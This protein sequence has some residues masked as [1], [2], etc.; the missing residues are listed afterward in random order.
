MRTTFPR[1]LSIE[2]GSELSHPVAPSSEG[3]CPSTGKSTMSSDGLIE[4]S[5]PVSALG[6]S[7]RCYDTCDDPIA[8][9]LRG[10]AAGQ[11]HQPGPG[12]LYALGPDTRTESLG[13]GAA[14]E[15]NRPSVG[16]PRRTGFE[17][18]L[19]HRARA[20]PRVRLCQRRSPEYALVAD[21]TGQA[22]AIEPLQEELCRSA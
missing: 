18:R 10:P 21:A 6:G 22:V 19:G 16:L 2:S 1:R 20:A 11:R 4:S 9:P 3:R 12:Q 5:L 8:D 14:P 13:S 15:S 17:D 7:R